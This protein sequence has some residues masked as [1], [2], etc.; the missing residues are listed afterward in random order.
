[1]EPEQ[2][3]CTV[4]PLPLPQTA[5]KSECCLR[6]P[7]WRARWNGLRRRVAGQYAGHIQIARGT[8]HLCGL[9]GLHCH[10]VLVVADGAVGAGNQLSIGLLGVAPNWL[11]CI[12][13]D[14]GATAQR[15]HGNGCG[16]W[17]SRVFPWR[18]TRRGQMRVAARLWYYRVV[19]NP[20]R[21][22][23]RTAR[24][25]AFNTGIVGGRPVVA[26]RVTRPGLP[27]RGAWPSRCGSHSAVA[28]GYT[29]FPGRQRRRGGSLPR[30]RRPGRKSAAPAGCTARVR[31]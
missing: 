8:T 13:H 16:H 28:Q 18:K 21:R 26:A 3:I 29:A 20:R 7:R 31:S 30:I 25:L 10:A 4:L 15:S 24:R 9:A 14:R 22:R 23:R 6:C 17:M 1:M 11:R 5:L 27:A 19:V 2:S 12:V